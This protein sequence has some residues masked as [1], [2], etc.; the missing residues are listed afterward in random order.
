MNYHKNRESEEAMENSTDF[1]AQCKALENQRRQLMNEIDLLRK[2]QDNA[3]DEPGMPELIKAQEELKK[4]ITKL[5]SNLGDERQQCKDNTKRRRDLLQKR[6]SALNDIAQ[7][8]ELNEAVAR[9]RRILSETQDLVL[10]ARKKKFLWELTA[11]VEKLKERFYLENTIENGKIEMFKQAI[12]RKES[13]AKAIAKTIKD[14][15]KQ[16]RACFKEEILRKEK[17]CEELSEK[18]LAI[19]QLSVQDRQ[20]TEPN[21]AVVSHPPASQTPKTRRKRQRTPEQAIQKIHRDEKPTSWKFFIT[22]DEGDQGKPLST[23]K[24]KFVKT[25]NP[26]LTNEISALDPHQ[27]Y[28]KLVMVTRLSP[29]QRWSMNEIHGKLFHGWKKLDIGAS[30]RA[31]LHIDEEGKMIRF[32]PGSHEV[33]KKIRRG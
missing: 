6:L 32:Y 8:V 21:H 14:H 24:R 12:Q 19:R 4:E 13:Q 18:I 31:L 17:E 15:L 11:P 29:Q 22:L 20:S 3:I 9:C 16:L 33:Y 25:V 27:L 30:Y 23:K 26:F 7:R 10:I 28:E 5:R 1:E 2:R